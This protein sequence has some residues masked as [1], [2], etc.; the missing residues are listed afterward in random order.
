MIRKVNT[1]F[2]HRVFL[3]LFAM[4]IFTRCR[5]DVSIEHGQA[6][7]GTGTDTL[8]VTS[9]NIERENTLRPADWKVYEVGREVLVAPSNWKSPVGKSGLVIMPP[10]SVDNSERLIFHRYSKDSSTLDYDK[11]AQQLTNKAFESFLLSK[12]NKLKK[13]ELLHNFFYERTAELEKNGTRYS[14]YNMTYISDSLV[15]DYT[16]ILTQARLNAYKG[17]LIKNMVGNLQLNHKYVLDNSNPVKKIV[18]ITP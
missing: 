2:D 7:V 11:F 15:Y 12:D 17:D 9:F 5:P 14:G 1:C 3:L 6:E 8:A 18:Y 13:I 4:V 10:N 16:I